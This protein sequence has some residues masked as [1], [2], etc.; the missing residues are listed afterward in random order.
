VNVAVFASAFHPSLGGVEELVRQ[1]AHQQTRRGERPLV[2]T[3]RWPKE[4]A[5]VDE[6]EGLPVRRY[7]FRVPEPNLHQLGGALLYGPGTRQQICSDLK[8]HGTDLIHVQCVSSNAYYALHASR[9]LRLPLVVTLQGELTMDAAQ[10]FQRSRFAQG[11][12]RTVLREADA[13]TACSGQTLEEAEIFSGQPFGDRG[14]VIYNG[15]RLRDFEGAAPFEW[16]NPY[17]LGIGRHVPQKGFDVL[18]RAFA[19]V[20]DAG[21]PSLDLLLAGDGD[22]RRNLEELARELRVD[23]RVHFL[24][25]VDREK[26]VRLFLGCSFFVL[27]S[28]H[29]PMG[30]VNLE[31]MAA[32]K[33]VLA[34]RVGGVP[35]LVTN[36]KTGLLVPGDNVEAL[37]S[38]IRCLAT[39]ADFRRRLGDAGRRRAADFDWSAIAAQYAEVYAGVSG[40]SRVLVGSK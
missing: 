35:E 32:G 5:A 38:G 29:E 3:N 13:I 1:L 23:G 14:R 34:S 39:D 2:V 11:L 24:G 40:E 27:P 7:P 30:I 36:E 10:I 26:A 19:Q 12:M 15:I 33:A 28:R 37:A 31:A 21:L 8:A 6:Y 25:R 18:L 20:V 4:L 16:S 17:V 9:R 22:E